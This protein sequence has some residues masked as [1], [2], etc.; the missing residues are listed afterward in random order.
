[1]W[2]QDDES[3]NCTNKSTG[4]LFRN[5]KITN[6]IM[7]YFDTYLSIHL[8]NLSDLLVYLT[9]YLSIWQSIRLSGNPSICLSDNP[10]ILFTCLMLPRA[11]IYRNWSIYLFICLSVFRLSICLSTHLFISLSI[12]LSLS[13][14]MFVDFFIY[15]SAYL[16]LCIHLP[17]WQLMYLF[18]WQSCRLSIRPSIHQF[19]TVFL[20]LPLSLS[21]QNFST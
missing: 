15:V 14:D 4:L 13:V 19:I 10:N 3:Y 8:S 6:Q 17:I 21:V 12:S 18:I 9:I 20:F 1:M 2:Q 16:P 11:T 5:H 7:I